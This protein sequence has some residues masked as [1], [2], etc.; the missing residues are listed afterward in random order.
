[1]S[2]SDSTGWPRVRAALGYVYLLLGIVSFG[3]YLALGHAT[4]NLVMGIVWL[5]L[6]TFWIVFIDRRDRRR[7]L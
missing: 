1:M 4:I 2:S 6:G 5:C 3:A 7:G